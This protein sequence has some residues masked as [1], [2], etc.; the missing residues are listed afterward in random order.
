MSESGQG[1]SEDQKDAAWAIFVLTIFLQKKYYLD[2]FRIRFGR[3][4][5][6]AS[7]DKDDNQFFFRPDFLIGIIGHKCRCGRYAFTLEQC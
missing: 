7:E 4:I 6:K 5:Q 2:Y 3:G 1:W